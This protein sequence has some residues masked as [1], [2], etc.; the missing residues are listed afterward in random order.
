MLQAWAGLRDPT[1]LPRLQYLLLVPG[2]GVDR[3]HWSRLSA[4]LEV[5]T[6][7][8]T[9]PCLGQLRALT[10]GATHGLRPEVLTSQN[11][12]VSLS[13]SLPGMMCLDASTLQTQTVSTALHQFV[14]HQ[15]M[16]GVQ[17]PCAC[18]CCFLAPAL[19]KL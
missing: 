4:A 16:A 15:S 14:L 7:C 8:C 6:P 9:L 18:Q 13:N 10:N 12:G 11:P 19:W 2:L 3:S 1:A 17:V 5:P